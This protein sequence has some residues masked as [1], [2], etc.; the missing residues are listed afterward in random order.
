MVYSAE[1]YT[2]AREER[3]TKSASLVILLLIAHRFLRTLN[4]TGDVWADLPDASDWLNL[5]ENRLY[6]LLF[7]IAG[8]RF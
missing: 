3:L 7:F 8:K 6:H 5:P 2:K 4:Q 1:I